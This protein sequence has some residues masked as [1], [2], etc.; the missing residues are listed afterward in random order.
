MRLK[1]K[2]DAMTI[3]SHY[4]LTFEAKPAF[5]LS[6]LKIAFTIMMTEIIEVGILVLPF[7]VEM[8]WGLP[9]TFPTGIFFS[10]EIF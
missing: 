2:K 6:R 4:C 7:K 1:K 9:M 10:K 5:Q 8:S 3:F